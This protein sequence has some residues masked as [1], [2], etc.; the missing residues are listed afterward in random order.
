M[1]IVNYIIK[2]LLVLT[3]I[4][5]VYSC[6]SEE[7]VEKIPALNA[8]FTQ[9]ID[10]ASAQVSFINLST[11]AVSYEWDFGDGTTS[12][13]INPVKTYDLGGTYSV[14][15]TVRNGDE[16]D[17]FQDDIVIEEIFNGGLI[18]NGDF[19]NGAAPW[20]QGVDDS[21]PAPVVTDSG[22][23]Y[24]Q[25]NVTNPDS[26]QP[27]LINM[28]QKLEITNGTTYVLT[29]DAWSD[30][31]RTL[32]AGIGLS[33]PPFDNDV[34]TVNLTTTLQ[35]FQLTLTAGGFGAPDARV[36]FDSNG[37]AGQVNIDNVSLVVQ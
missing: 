33:G 37:D 14:E 2:S 23:T 15:L 34:D 19:E 29:F 18:V 9:T 11:N 24:Y 22:N 5:A 3:V 7:V 10:Q 4:T 28:S 12:T 36:L 17:T 27:Y 6:E 13:L 30:V 20:I 32:I 16:S 8:E 35:T 1:K 26:T 21:N 25:V 31:N